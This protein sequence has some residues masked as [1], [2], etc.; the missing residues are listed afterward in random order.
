MSR[1]ALLAVIAAVTTFASV[2]GAGAQTATAIGRDIYLIPG[3]FPEGQQPDG[4]S[5][6]LLAPKG[7]VVIDTGRQATHTQQIVDFA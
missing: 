3:A 5:V 1:R 4:N 6:V 2:N 7:L